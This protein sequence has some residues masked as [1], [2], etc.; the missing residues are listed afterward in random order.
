M[1][2]HRRARRVMLVKQGPG[3][4]TILQTTPEPLEG[5]PGEDDYGPITIAPPARWRSTLPPGSQDRPCIQPH[6]SGGIAGAAGTQINILGAGIVG[7]E[8]LGSTWTNNLASMNIASGSTFDL[9]GNSII[10]D[11]LTGSGTV[12]NTFSSSNQMTVGVNGGNGTFSGNITSGAGATIVLVKA[13]AGNQTLSGAGIT[14]TGATTVSAGTLTLQDTYCLRF[15][16]NGGFRGD[17]EPLIAASL[18]G[19]EIKRVLLV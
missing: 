18:P 13:G 19:Q 7:N 5:S 1:A 11:A 4:L 2:D 15:D 10:V 8:F 3:T 16:R 9:R 12:E 6:S 14:Y 17:I